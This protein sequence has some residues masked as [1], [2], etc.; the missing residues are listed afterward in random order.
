VFA[1]RVKDTKVVLDNGR[2]ARVETGADIKSF[3]D[4]SIVDDSVAYVGG[5]ATVFA[6]DPASNQFIRRTTT[7]KKENGER[8]IGTTL[9]E[10]HPAHAFVRKGEAYYGPATLFGRRFYTAY[11][12]VMGPSGAVVGILY[13]GIPIETYFERHSG[14]MT[15]VAGI[16][17]T[18]ALLVCLLGGVVANRLFRPLKDMAGRVESLAAGDLAAPVPHVGR[19]DEIG[20]LA[21][22]VEILRDAS[23]RARDLEAGRSAGEEQERQRRATLDQ[24]IHEFRDQVS[25]QLRSLTAQAADMRGRA[26]T[27]ASSAQEATAAIG[28]ASAGAHEA[29]TNVQTVASAAEELSASINEIGSQL[30]HA[31]AVAVQALGEAEATDA[32]IAGLARAAQRIGDVV[33]LIRSIAEQTNL[34]ALNATIEAARAGEAGKGF[35]VV[36]SEVKTLATQT[37]KATEEISRQIASVQGSTEAAVHAIRGITGRVRAIN[38]TTLGMAQA[39]EEQSAATMEISRNVAETARGTADIADGLGAVTGA[40]ER[41]AVTAGGVTEAART[42]DAIASRLDGEIDRFLKRVAA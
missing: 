41:T 12:P 3:S 39:M 28:S 27:M 13:I 4:T 8:A 36:A 34:L 5:N 26:E 14:I 31:K 7:V 30:D 16:A 11:H 2:V 29:S 42:L 35:A 18:L 22:A 10:G 38:D 25:S 17:A 40:A 21:R 19:S 1:G 33:D 37:A 15:M 23:G 24:A 9:A 6:F 32:E 20:T